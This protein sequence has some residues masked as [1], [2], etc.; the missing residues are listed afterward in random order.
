[1]SRGLGCA[2]AVLFSVLVAGCDGG[3]K[4]DSKAEP[5]APASE[6]APAALLGEWELVK[7]DDQDFAGQGILVKFTQ[8]G[9]HQWGPA[10]SDCSYSFKAPDVLMTDCTKSVPDFKVT[11]TIKSI[12]GSALVLENADERIQPQPLHTLK[13]K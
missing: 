4:D 11:Y 13:R 10:M 12:D 1:M 2:L 8:D 5:A 9:K 7:Q 3:G 6:A